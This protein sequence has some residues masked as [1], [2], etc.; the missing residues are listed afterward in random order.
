[1][2][3]MNLHRRPLLAGLLASPLI[4]PRAARAQDAKLLRVG[5]QRGGIQPLM[6][7]AGV[8]SDLPYRLE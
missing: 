3:A 2:P 7:A 6:E 8:L 4:L 5:D 1:M